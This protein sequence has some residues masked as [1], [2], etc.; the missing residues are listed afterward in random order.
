MTYS[1]TPKRGSRVTM[2]GAQRGAALFISLIVLVAMTLS[3]IAMMRSVDTNVLIAGNLAFRSAAMSAADAGIESART[4][5]TTQSSGVLTNDQLPGYYANWQESFNPGTFD[6]AA[7]GLLVG[8]DGNGNE[9]RYVAH[10]M[11]ADS[12]KT[13]D[14]TDCFKVVSASS[15]S[16]Q[17]GGSYGISPLSGSAQPYFRITTRVVGPRNTVSYVQAFVY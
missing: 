2:L 7:Q 17:Q 12:A 11:C 13:V 16:S 10:R 15:G 8:N 14:G 5:L 6:W 3:G 1:A 4:W 9:I